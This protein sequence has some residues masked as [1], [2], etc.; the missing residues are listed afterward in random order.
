M[1]ATEERTPIHFMLTLKSISSR[2]LI[3][4]ALSVCGDRLCHRRT[5]SGVEKVNCLYQ[6]M[7]TVTGR[8]ICAADKCTAVGCRKIISSIPGPLTD[9][10]SGKGA[11]LSLKICAIKTVLYWQKHEKWPK[12]S[13]WS[14]IMLTR[15]PAFTRSW[16]KIN[17]ARGANVC[18]SCKQW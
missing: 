6:Q 1:R 18:L 13:N 2:Q 4:E 3:I 8:G 5:W 15:L 10:I 17:S 7:I 16:C 12:T 11:E 14:L 9:R